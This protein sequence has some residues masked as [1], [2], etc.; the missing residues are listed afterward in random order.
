MKNRVNGGLL[1]EVDTSFIHFRHSSIIFY[2]FYY[3]SRD[4][5]RDAIFGYIAVLLA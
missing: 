2:S 4:Y 5:D 3:G 1:L